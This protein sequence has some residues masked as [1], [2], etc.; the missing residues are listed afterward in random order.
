MVKKT[1]FF[2]LLCFL[3]VVSVCCTQKKSNKGKKVHVAKTETGYQLIRDGQP[4][5]I[6][7][8]SGNGFIKELAEAGG[9]TLRV[10]DTVNLKQLLD[11]CHKYSIAL[12]ADIPIPRNTTEYNFYEDEGHIKKLKKDIATLVSK[13]KD[14]P[15][16]LMWNL[17][18][19]VEYPKIYGKQKFIKTFNELLEIIH[20]NDPDHPVSTAVASVSK[21]QILSMLYHSPELDLIGMN[22][23]GNIWNMEADLAKIPFYGGDFPFYISEWGYDGPWEKNT[24]AWA[25]TIEP[26]DTQKT[27]KIYKIYNEATAFKNNNCVGNLVFFWGE[28]QET[29]HTWFSL[30]DEGGHKSASYHQISELW[31]GSGRNTHPLI[32]ENINLNNKTSIQNI[33][34]APES[35]AK[36]TIQLNKTIDS[37]ATQ[38]WDVFP[39]NWYIKPDKKEAKPKSIPVKRISIT[40]NEFV[41]KVP[42]KEGPYRVFVKV[43]DGNG[44]FST[45]N[46]PFYVLN[47]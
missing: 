40:K 22:I 23:F 34:L 47:L 18:N 21:Q 27:E 2:F 29:T 41:F 35:V 12:I 39:E 15:A 4:F 25:A 24:T 8:A 3:I 36:A 45:A 20:E 26:D 10:Y 37:T 38:L 13:Y 5:T 19:E 7:G 28:K 46:I 16:L 31:N 42:K 43:V 32:I 6:K 44:N 33:L 17:G 9:N 30:V 11:E 1:A 14:H